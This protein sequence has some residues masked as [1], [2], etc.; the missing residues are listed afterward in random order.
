M[1]IR[2][3]Y[4]AD[5]DDAFMAWA[6]A[7]GRVDSRGLEWEHVVSDIQSLNEW[8]VEGRLEVTAISMHAYPHVR[9]QYA[10]LPNG[11]SMGRGY[12]PVVVAQRALSP[13]EL[14][15]VEIAVPGTLTTAFLVLR[16]FLGGDFAYREVRFDRILDE[17]TSGRAAAGL[18]LHE[19]QLTYPAA[20][21]EKCVDLGEWWTAKTGLPLPLGVVVARRDLGEETIERVA[22][23]L[24]D[25]IR[26]GLDHRPEAMRFAMQF[27]RGLDV[28]TAD[29]FVAM[30]VNDLT[31]DMGEEGRRAVDELLARVG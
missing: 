15:E 13:D 19:G 2:F 23:V 24:R 12:G 1:R 11:A 6:L 8:A 5:A 20:G 29:R 30:Y 25:S 7:E 31:L 18:V 4:S 22:D 27:G 26:E 16:E 10:L 17:V 9:E 28:E 14:R 3:G 21:L